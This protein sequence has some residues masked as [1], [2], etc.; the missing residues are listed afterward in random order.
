MEF[1]TH[2]YLPSPTFPCNEQFKVADVK[3]KVE[4]VQ[5]PNLCYQT[6]LKE[7]LLLVISLY[8]SVTITH[9]FA[10]FLLQEPS[11]VWVSPAPIMQSVMVHLSS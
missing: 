8:Q 3:V 5:Q 10:I 11:G 4:K 1:A 7:V 2:L 6:L 9:S